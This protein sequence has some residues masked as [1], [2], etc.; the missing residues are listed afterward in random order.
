MTWAD[1]LSGLDYVEPITA[2][3][4]AFSE[5]I[6]TGFAPSLYVQVLEKVPIIGEF[7]F[8]AIPSILALAIFFGFW[9]IIF[10]RGAR[11]LT[12]F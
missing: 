8:Y 11:R 10:I 3:P 9:H 1:Y 2:H 6:E 4:Q 12:R 7:M 5:I